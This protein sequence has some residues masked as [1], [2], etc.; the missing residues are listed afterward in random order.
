MQLTF[1]VRWTCH[2]LISNLPVIPLIELRIVVSC[3]V[4]TVDLSSALYLLWMFDVASSVLHQ[5]QMFMQL[6]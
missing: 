1:C 6:L 5:K 2:I 4:Y 3:V